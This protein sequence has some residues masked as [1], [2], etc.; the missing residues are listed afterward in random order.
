MTFLD[1]GLRCGELC[2]LK[3]EDVHLEGRNSCVK[4]IG[5]GQKERM[6]YLGRRAHEALLT[7][8]TFVGPHDVKLSTEQHSSSASPEGN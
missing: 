4:V 6:V 1:T 3:L 2:G 8:H 7:Y 5:K